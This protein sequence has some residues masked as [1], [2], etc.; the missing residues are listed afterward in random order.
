MFIPLFIYVAVPGLG[1]YTQ[2]L[3]SSLLPMGSLVAACELL[4][5]AGGLQFPDKGLNLGPLFWEHGV[6]ATGPPYE[7]YVSVFSKQS[8]FPCIT[9]RGEVCATLVTVLRQHN[10]L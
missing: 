6:L 3:W 8:L 9:A 4:V 1:C 2:K 5:V 10:P 7:V